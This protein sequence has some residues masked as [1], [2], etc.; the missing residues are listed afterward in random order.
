MLLRLSRKKGRAAVRERP[1]AALIPFLALRQGLAADRRPGER[2]DQPWGVL[3][4]L[5]APVRLWETE[6][7]CA[8]DAAYD[9]ETLDRELR[10]GRLCWYGAGKER[11][12][13]CRPEDLELLRAGSGEGGGAPASR[14][15]GGRTEDP[16]FSRPRDFWE[17]RDAAGMDNRGCAEALWRDAWEGL[18]SADSWEPLR[19]GIEGGFIP[20]ETGE[21]AGTYRRNGTA[22]GPPPGPFGRM[23]R[24]PPALRRRWRSGAPVGG[25][26]FSLLPGEDAAAE[27]PLYREECDRDRVRLLVARWGVLCRPLLEREAPA[28]SWSRLLP[29]MRRMELAGELSAGRFFAGVNS[30]QFA[31]PRILKDLEEADD[32]QGIFWMNAADPASPAG[33]GIGGLD[34][35]FPP[36]SAAGRLCFR[37][38]KLAALSSGGSRHVRIY[39]GP[40]DPELPAILAFLA[41]PRRRKVRPEKKVCV[42]TVNGKP[43]VSSGGY[44]EALKTLGFIADRGRLTLW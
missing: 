20:A 1:A 5:A 11:A 43:A 31:P 13:F 34:P 33:I 22:G 17:I 37:G 40:G 36:R 6:I 8:R 14:L 25:N 15:M 16:F 30:L 2:P 26:W 35:R 7:F 4:C 24:I 18:L 12:G 28:F 9:G 10:E 39:A 21:P 41:I 19:R 27:D 42:E 32:L 38:S 3:S 44:A 29:A 23:P